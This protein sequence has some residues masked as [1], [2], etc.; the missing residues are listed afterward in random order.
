M[1]RRNKMAPP[2]S[3][4]KTATGSTA[5]GTTGVRA[6]MMRRTIALAPSTSSFFVPGVPESL[7]SVVEPFVPSYV[8]EEVE[9]AQFALLSLAV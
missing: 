3:T 4:A 9:F 5:H 6:L 1:R 2:P 7:V 8:N